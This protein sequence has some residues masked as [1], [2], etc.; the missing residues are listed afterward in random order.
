ML[1]LNDQNAAG[2]TPVQDPGSALACSLCEMPADAA[3]HPAQHSALES[4]AEFVTR[5]FGW[6][7]WPDRDARERIGVWG[8]GMLHN[9]RL[10]D[11]VRY[12]GALAVVR[13]MWF[14]SVDA[15]VRRTARDSEQ[16]AVLRD[17]PDFEAYAAMAIRALGHR[18]CVSDELHLA[19]GG[20]EGLFPND[21][22]WFPAG[23]ERDAWFTQLSQSGMP[24]DVKLPDLAASRAPWMQ[25]EMHT[26]AEMLAMA[27]ALTVSPCIRYRRDWHPL[28]DADRLQRLLGG[29]VL[30]KTV[31]AWIERVANHGADEATQA[32]RN[33]GVWLA[34]DQG[35]TL[36]LAAPTMQ[37]LFGEPDAMVDY[38]KNHCAGVPVTTRA[39]RSEAEAGVFIPWPLLS[40]WLTRWIPDPRFTGWKEIARQD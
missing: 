38:L 29:R 7:Q 37:D 34:R 20:T 1:T 16:E 2:L 18:W 39:F 17:H 28:L 31:A 8:G 26:P 21:F 12:F 22:R 36:Q 24:T 23:P 9:P 15:A 14:A 4:L 33:H 3:A 11:R 25:V 35:L 5:R 30:G 40:Q 32:L 6:D 19:Y 13:S 10:P 27:R